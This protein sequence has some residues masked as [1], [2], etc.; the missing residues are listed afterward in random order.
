MEKY[1]VV[2]LNLHIFVVL[3]G[4]TQHD[5]FLKIEQS[6][7]QSVYNMDMPHYYVI[8]LLKFRNNPGRNK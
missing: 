1:F 3:V 5:K 4:L 2:E 6:T 7:S 8:A